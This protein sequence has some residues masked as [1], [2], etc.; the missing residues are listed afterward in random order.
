MALCDDRSRDAIFVAPIDDGSNDGLDAGRRSPEDI[1]G[2]LHEG[3]P[4]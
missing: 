1:A 3:R 4:E 2:S